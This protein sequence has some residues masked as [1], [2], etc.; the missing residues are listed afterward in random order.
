MQSSGF[1]LDPGAVV[2][3]LPIADQQKIEILRPWPVMPG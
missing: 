3:D 2:A 1:T